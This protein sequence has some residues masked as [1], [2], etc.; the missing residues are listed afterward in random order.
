MQI[1]D[2][3]GLLLFIGIM[4]LVGFLSWWFVVKG[5]T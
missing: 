1:E 5:N 3:L 2:P 4:S